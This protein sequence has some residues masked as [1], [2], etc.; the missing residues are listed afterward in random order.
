MDTRTVAAVNGVP[1]NVG[2]PITLASGALLTVNA[3][4]SCTYDPTAVAAFQALATGQSATDTFT[5]TMQD[6]AACR[7]RRR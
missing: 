5:Y 4:G 3:D 7:P 1:A 6:A 2:T